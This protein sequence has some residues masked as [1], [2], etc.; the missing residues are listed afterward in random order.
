MKILMKL[1]RNWL[2]GLL[3]FAL[4][5][6][7]LIYTMA[8]ESDPSVVIY[9]T[10]APPVPELDAASVKQGE[11]LYAQ[12]CA[13]CHGKNL[14]GAAGW[15]TALPDGS[16]PPPPHDSS[17]HTWHH[18]DSLLMRITADGGFPPTPNTKMPAFGAIL[19]EDETASI[20]DFIKSYWG[21]EER[22]FQWWISVTR[23]QYYE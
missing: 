12:Y 9:N 18:P 23:G 19:T 20:L 16:Y 17:G 22:E 6:A 21:D 10:P 14:E 15:K 13:A 3:A 2:I 11:K 4:I 8:G 1:S 7:G 5:I